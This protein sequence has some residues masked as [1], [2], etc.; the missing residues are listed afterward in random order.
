MAPVIISGTFRYT[1]AHMLHSF[2]DFLIFSELSRTPVIR[3]VV[4]Q[5]V[6]LLGFNGTVRIAIPYSRSASRLG[7]MQNEGHASAAL[8][9]R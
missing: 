6:L 3:I 8:P 4:L 7:V 5:C 9:H 1:A 2:C